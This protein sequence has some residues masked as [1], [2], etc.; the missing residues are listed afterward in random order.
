MIHKFYIE[1]Y[2]NK[3]SY[4][5]KLFHKEVFKN[6]NNNFNLDRYFDIDKNRNLIWKED[7][8]HVYFL[9]VL[10][11]VPLILKVFHNEDKKKSLYFNKDLL[12][13]LSYKFKDTPVSMGYYF[14]LEYHFPNTFIFQK[15]LTL[16]NLTYEIKPYILEKNIIS[17]KTITHGDLHFFKNYPVS[18]SVFLFYIGL[19][20]NLKKSIINFYKRDFR[21][22]IGIDEGYRISMLEYIIKSENPISKLKKYNKIYDKYNL[23]ELESHF[24]LSLFFIHLYASTSLDQFENQIQL[25][26]GKINKFGLKYISYMSQ[27]S[28]LLDDKQVEEKIIK[29][30]LE[31]NRKLTNSL[32]TQLLYGN[33]EVVEL[34]TI[35]KLREEGERQKHCVA[36]YADNIIEN[37]YRIFSFRKKINEKNFR[38]TVSFRIKNGFYKTDQIKTFRNENPF[39]K[40]DEEEKS[41]LTTNISTI[42]DMLNEQ[43]QEEDD[44]I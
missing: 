30:K 41:F 1:N 26:V 38:V 15:T 3:L 20:E 44:F 40:L 31:L 25:L 19:P 14:F 10:I 6:Y 8:H 17:S 9:N 2:E 36:G 29:E 33:W 22:K 32:G 18:L 13:Y 27:S 42:Q 37:N 43:L 34:D 35:A 4:T 28:K 5:E 24:E 39:I 21:A 23:E 16:N 11:L 12:I 7:I